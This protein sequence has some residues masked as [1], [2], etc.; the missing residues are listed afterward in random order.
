MTFARFA[1]LLVATVSLV[2]TSL[3]AADEAEVPQVRKEQET[4]ACRVPPCLALQLAGGPTYRKLFGSY[5][6]GA[7][8]RV[9]IGGRGHGYAFYALGTGTFATTEYGLRIRGYSL[10]GGGEHAFGRLR[11]GG[12]IQIARPAY[13]RATDGEEAS[14]MGIGVHI[15]VTVD[16]VKLEE[17]GIFVGADFAIEALGKV[18]VWGPTGLV[19]FRY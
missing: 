15:F 9:A 18:G 5:F 7:D 13:T 10:G 19:G 4:S 6:T 17:H 11:L 2:V 1:S 8:L 14:S 12:A 3:A 16:V